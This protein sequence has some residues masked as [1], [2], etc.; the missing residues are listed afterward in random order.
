[1]VNPSPAL[2]EDGPGTEAVA[3]PAARSENA[4]PPQDLV[5]WDIAVRVAAR[6]GGREPLAESYLYHS[7]E[8]DLAELTVQAEAL[9]GTETG[10]DPGSPARIRVVDREAWAKANVASF[11]RLL[12][13]LTE[14][15]GSRMAKTPVAP[16]GRAVAGAEVGALLGWMSTRV[17]GQY[18]PLTHEG[19]E[20]AQDIVYY[21]GPNILALEKRYGFP[22]RQ[23]RLW[24][25]L[26]EL[27]HRAQFMGV[28]W[29][30]E[31]FLSLVDASL[32]GV[33]ADP[34]RVVE[35][36]RRAVKQKREGINPLDEGGLVA[37]LASPDQLVAMQKIQGLMSLLEGHGD[38]TMERA[39]VGVVPQGERFRAVL[40]QRRQSGGFT[41][42]LQKLLG[43]EAKLMQYQQGEKFIETVEKAHGSQA[44]GLMWSD[45]EWIPTLAEIRRPQLWLDR[46]AAP[47]A[48]AGAP[49]TP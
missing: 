26:H 1:L 22:P 45:P 36:L 4:G 2:S 44:L 27:T 46:A 16:L 14:R 7:L 29:M 9:V 20:D 32:A 6:I 43:I 41:K 12:Q 8:P 19:D 40:H 30:R 25:A 10:L 39:G 18:D 38:T 11:R 21:V 34:K 28:P 37:L 24:L 33:D 3:E 15:L 31:H 49:V 47:E 48:S 23:F 35:A 42:L 5:A 17:L 13:P